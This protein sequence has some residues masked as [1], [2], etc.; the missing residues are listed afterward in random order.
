MVLIVG[1]L[2]G[3]FAW[4]DVIATSYVAL[5]A[6]VAVALVRL[7]WTSSRSVK[8]MGVRRMSAL[9]PWHFVVG[10]AL[11]VLVAASFV[12]MYLEATGQGA[13]DV[14]SAFV[15]A[16]LLMVSAVWWATLVVMWIF[17]SRT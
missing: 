8:A 15:F 11:L 7:A 17:R 12:W 10:G 14:D 9:Q 1:V 13:R 16:G 4:P 6:L 3:A 2:I 5:G